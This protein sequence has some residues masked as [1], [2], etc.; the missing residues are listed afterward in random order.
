MGSHRNPNEAHGSLNS[1][2][3]VSSEFS[4]LQADSPAL[5][6]S[7]TATT[8]SI[9]TPASIDRHLESLDVQDASGHEGL[10]SNQPFKVN[11]HM[12]LQ[13]FDKHFQKSCTLWIHDENFSSQDVLFNPDLLP[14]RSPQDGRVLRV[15]YTREPSN[16][17]GRGLHYVRKDRGSN[18]R[19]LEPLHGEQTVDT[20]SYIFVCHQNALTESA[21][22]RNL[23]ISV[24]KDVATVHGFHNRTTVLVEDAGYDEHLA[25]H[26]E[27]NFS[28][29]LNRADLWKTTV[30]E[31]SRRRCIFQGQE[32]LFLGSIKVIIKKLFVSGQRVPSALFSASSKPIFRSTAARFIIG[33]Q[34]SR[35]LLS[36]D[37]DL[38]NG[39]QWARAVEFLS[40]LL[41][42]WRL[43]MTNHMLS[44]VL[45]ARVKSTSKIEEPKVL[46]VDLYRVV[47]SDLPVFDNRGILR[48]VQRSFKDFQKEITHQ[49]LRRS[50]ADSEMQLTSAKDGN[51]L[52]AIN[53]A[54][55]ACWLD[56]LDLDFVRTQTSIVMLCPNSGVFEVDDNLLR[57]TGD[58]LIDRSVGVELVCLASP[59]LHVVPIFV[60]N[61]HVHKTSRL[62]TADGSKP[63]GDT[64]SLRSPTSTVDSRR[65]GRVGNSV[66]QGY[67]SKAGEPGAHYVVPSWIETSFYQSPHQHKSIDIMKQFS[68]SHDLQGKLKAANSP[69]KLLAVAKIAGGGLR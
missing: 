52:E 2:A 13:A 4:I 38:S 56:D 18:G 65:D 61:Q 20:H 28:D 33:I 39:I 30:S 44:V 63:G 66:E 59:P 60:L 21:K 34:V 53:V 37:D 31:L 42:R 27:L 40:S 24:C 51:I 7:S 43:K 50:H 36:F 26:V 16:D 47:I 9:L 32:L 67:R 11:I 55:S 19:A 15:T 64:D 49:I 10:A 54:I 12:P 5:I 6:R 58:R 17:R 3:N 8:P 41:E 25:S 46:P 48:D 14:Q 62:T 22:H 57:L 68:E 45:F 69:L 35:E 29:P 1:T 23:Q